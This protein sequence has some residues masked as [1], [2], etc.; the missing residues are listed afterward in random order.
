MT[1]D[2]AT[3]LDHAH[4]DDSVFEL[5]PDYRA[6]LVAAEDLRPGPSDDT[7]EKLLAHAEE[8]ARLRLAG[9]APEELAHVAAWRAAFRAFGAKP[10]RTRTSVE[11]LLRRAADGLPRVDRLTDAYNAVS[12]A[13][14]APLGGEDIDRYTGPLRLVRATGEEAFETMSAGEPAVEHPAPGEVVWRDDAGVTCRRWNWRQC[15]RTR[16]TESTTRAVFV[17]DA[18]DPLTDD[19]VLAVGTALVDALRATSPGV[20]TRTRLLARGRD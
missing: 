6:L 2:L 5:R 3:W 15:V 10:Q 11:A 13:H 8:E 9:T 14:T 7:S 17:I 16:L 20:R 4:V 1:Q 18:L 12:V 19:D